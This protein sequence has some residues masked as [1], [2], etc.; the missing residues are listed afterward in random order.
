MFLNRQP[1][2]NLAAPDAEQSVALSLA[3]IR[4]GLNAYRHGYEDQSFDPKRT[5]AESVGAIHEILTAL[6]YASTQEEMMKHCVGTQLLLASPD[7]T[8]H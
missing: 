6:G 8:M 3:L 5:I 7:N 4:Y 1:L 2:A